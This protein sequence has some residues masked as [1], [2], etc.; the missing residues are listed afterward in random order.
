MR[1]G[2]VSILSGLCK[3]VVV[4]EASDGEAAVTVTREARPH[5]VL[6]DVSMPGM[7][8]L[9]A[10]RLITAEMP[11][12]KVVALTMHHSNEM[13]RAMKSAGAAGYIT[14]STDASELCAR[15]REVLA[16]A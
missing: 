6:M 14:K 16:V 5:V 4:G 13:R 11:G 3:F 2:L 15:I 10:T 12:I 7:N 9:E 1:Q 8:G